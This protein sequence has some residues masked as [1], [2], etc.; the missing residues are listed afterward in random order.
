MHTPQSPTIIGQS[1]INL[2]WYA[3]V[4]VPKNT[5]HLRSRDP[6]PKSNQKRSS[7]P[8]EP[9]LATAYRS[10]LHW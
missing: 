9:I 1:R 4:E 6:I 10:S 7:E 3:K 2:G 5:N 8:P